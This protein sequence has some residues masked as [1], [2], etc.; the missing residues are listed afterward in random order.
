MRKHIYEN[1]HGVSIHIAVPWGEGANMIPPPVIQFGHLS[2]PAD[3]RFEY[4][5]TTDTIKNPGKGPR[6]TTPVSV[7]IDEI[8]GITEGDDHG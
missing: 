6:G 3:T 5:T 7:I 8:A 1:A 4:K 2:S